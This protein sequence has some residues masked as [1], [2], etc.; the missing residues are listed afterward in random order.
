[1]DKEG[2]LERCED[3][4]LVKEIID[5]YA[6]LAK[7]LRGIVGLDEKMAEIAKVAPEAFLRCMLYGNASEARAAAK[8]VLDR[9]QGRPVERVVSV[10]MNYSQASLT[11]VNNE[12]RQFIGRIIADGGGVGHKQIEESGSGEDGGDNVTEG[13]IVSGD[14]DRAVC[15]EQ[16]SEEVFGVEGAGSG[17]SGREQNWKNVCGGDGSLEGNKAG[18]EG[19][20]DCGESGIRARSQGHDLSGDQGVV[21]AASDQEGE[22]KLDGGSDEDG[23]SG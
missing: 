1:M 6:P 2:L 18:G 7:R 9:V 16:N 23:H 20:S 13:S 14:E 12:L 3:V 4:E 11:E 19:I 21:S 15:A 10:S 22:A 17:V 5:V 8:D